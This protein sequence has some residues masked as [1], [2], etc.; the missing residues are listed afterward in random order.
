MYKFQ[1]LTPISGPISTNFKISGISG[2]R[3]GLGPWMAVIQPPMYKQKT[4][5]AQNTLILTICLA[6]MCTNKQTLLRI[7]FPHTS[8]KKILQLSIWIHHSASKGWLLW[9]MGAQQFQGHVWRPS[10]SKVC[11]SLVDWAVDLSTD[12]WSRMTYAVCV[13]SDPWRTYPP[14][15]VAL[16]VCAVRRPSGLSLSS[17]YFQTLNPI[18]YKLLHRVLA[19]WAPPRSVCRQK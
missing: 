2:Q 3:P 18:G 13:Q 5:E 4:T 12:L 14:A 9:W 10:A 11:A 6:V 1:D 17:L 16:K 19:V 7:L 15:D 8:P